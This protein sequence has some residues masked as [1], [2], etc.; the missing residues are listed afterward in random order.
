MRGRGGLD[1]AKKVVGVGGGASSG[2]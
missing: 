1:L 2:M